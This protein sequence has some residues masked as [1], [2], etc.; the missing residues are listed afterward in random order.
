VWVFTRY[1]FFSIACAQHQDGTIDSNTVMVRARLKE[2]LQ[3]LK[4][5]FP[6]SDL[7]KAQILNSVGTD[8]KYRIILP[9]DEWAKILADLATEQSWS[10]FKNETS[11]FARLEK[12]TNA[13]VSALHKIWGI[14]F[15]LQT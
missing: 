1:G 7:G 2:H 13:Y 8:Y 5:R 15:D 3:N 9:K 12:V 4:D 10:N 14:M 6:L 11:R